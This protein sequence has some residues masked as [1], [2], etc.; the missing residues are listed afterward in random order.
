MDQNQ[1]SIYSSSNPVV[2][3]L[4]NLFAKLIKTKQTGNRSNKT[5][6]FIRDVDQTLFPFGYRILG[7]K[8]LFPNLIRLW[9]NE[10]VVQTDPPP[11]PQQL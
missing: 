8:A 5:P 9:D 3:K 7:R 11:E 10:W 2:T 6:Y 1:S 4:V